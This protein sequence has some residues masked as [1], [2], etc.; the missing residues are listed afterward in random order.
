MSMIMIRMNAL[1]L[2]IKKFESVKKMSAFVSIHFEEN[3]LFLKKFISMTAYCHSLKLYFESMFLFESILN[4]TINFSIIL[5]VNI[6]DLAIECLFLLTHQV[7][8]IC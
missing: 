6:V 7:A 4:S 1:N 2:L 5:L 3:S 8:R